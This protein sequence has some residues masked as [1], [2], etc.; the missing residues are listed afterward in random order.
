MAKVYRHTAWVRVT[1]WI[2]ALAMVMLILTGI[3]IHWAG[4]APLFGRMSNAR[5]LHFLFA[6]VLLSCYGFRAYYYLIGTK[7]GL[8]IVFRPSD[9]PGFVRL[10]QYYTVGMFRGAPK[11]EFGPYNP[12]QKFAYSIWPLVVI[13]IAATGFAMYY[14]ATWAWFANPL[15]GLG[16]VRLIHFLLATFFAL[17]ALGHIYLGTTGPTLGAYYRGILTGWEEQG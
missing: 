10:A 11:P 2:H 5:Y 12:G 7:K 16:Y 4:H 15:G 1:H 17:S 9:V 3:Q 6:W 14:P 13:P 8:E